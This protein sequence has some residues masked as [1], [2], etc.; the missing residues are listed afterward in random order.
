M[1]LNFLN[2]NKTKAVVMEFGPSGPCVSQ[3]V[4]LGPLAPYLKSTVSNLS[5]KLN[6]DFEIDRKIAAV[7][8]S[9]FSFPSII[10]GRWLK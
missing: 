2:F 5:Y 3:R 8:E 9:N 10:L 1:V 6:S 7:V 4:D